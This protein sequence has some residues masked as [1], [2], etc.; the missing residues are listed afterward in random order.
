MRNVQPASLTTEE[1]VKEAD[2]MML[3]GSLPLAW[4]EEILARL[5]K[6]IHGGD[7]LAHDPRQL[8]LF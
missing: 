8:T 6:L 3:D 1:L 5:E 4:Q 7:T 2:L